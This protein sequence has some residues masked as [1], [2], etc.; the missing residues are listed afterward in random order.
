MEW[1]K[2]WAINKKIIDPISPRFIAVTSEN[3]AK[4]TILN[5][6]EVVSYKSVPL[7]PMNPKFGDRPFA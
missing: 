5:A 2:I 4:L 7:H 6:S 1:D 3:V